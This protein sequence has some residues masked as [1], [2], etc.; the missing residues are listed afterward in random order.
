MKYVYKIVAAIGA[1]AVAPVLFF[2]D[3]FNYEISSFAVQI[4]AYLAQM[5]GKSDLTTPNGEAPTGIADT[6]SFYELFE[7]FS[8]FDASG[9]ASLADTLGAIFT[10]VVLFAVVSLMLV[11]CAVVTAI[12]A[13]V[14]KNNRKVI[15]SS[16]VGIGLSFMLS[17]IFEDIA[18]PVMDGTVNLGTLLDNMWAS[19][20]GSIDK[21]SLSTDFWFIPAIFGAIILWT[22]LYNYTLPENEKR[23][24]KLMLGEADDQ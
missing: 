20:L 18:A 1:L 11:I 19:L 6:A 17:S 16:I 21:L 13:I 7:V 22:V 12:F 14:A 23:E 8:G 9:E 3:I 10:P 2:T 24:R 5:S 4:L 15:Y